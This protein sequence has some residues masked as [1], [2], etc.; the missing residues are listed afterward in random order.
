[1]MHFEGIWYVYHIHLIPELYQAV[2][3]DIECKLQKNVI[4]WTLFYRRDM[5]SLNYSISILLVWRKMLT[6]LI[7]ARSSE[8]GS[9]HLCEQRRFGRSAQSRQNLSCSLKQAMSQEEPSD[10]KPDPWPLWMT[11]HEQLKFFMTRNARRHKFA[12]R[13]PYSCASVNNNKKCAIGRS[14]NEQKSVLW[15]KMFIFVV[16][17]M[18]MIND[19]G[20]LT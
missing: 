4:S 18:N 14:E 7:W 6:S 17:Y 20:N 15:G 2:F 10:R 19:V 9:Y 11:G 5:A 8:F 16:A 12:W 1:M 13:G 3:F